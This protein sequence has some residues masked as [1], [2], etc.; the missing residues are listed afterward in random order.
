MFEIFRKSQTI[1]GMNS[2]NLS[3]IRPNNFKKAKRLA[4][5][6]LRSKRVLDKNGLPVPKLIAKIKTRQELD[7]FNFSTLPSSFVLKP[8]MGLGGEGNVVVYGRKKN[9]DNVWMKAD[10]S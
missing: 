2:R 1:L 3:F 6:K 8:N 10:R 7:S 5:D 9:Q 4:D